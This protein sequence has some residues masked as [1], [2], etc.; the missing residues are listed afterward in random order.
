MDFY[1]KPD[2]SAHTSIVRRNPSYSG[3]TAQVPEVSSDEAPANDKSLASVKTDG[4]AGLRRVT[5]G[6]SGGTGRYLVVVFTP[7][8]GAA[9]RA[10]SD[11]KDF[12]NV[13][14]DF[15]D[16]PVAASNG[17]GNEPL[18]ISEVTAF[19][20]PS[21]S[22]TAIP[23]LPPPDRTGDFFR[24]PPADTTPVTTP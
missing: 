18:S 17:Y 10:T 14:T 6:L 20:P 2:A 23:Q 7:A 5:V 13:V 8:G 3:Q 16:S 9:P 4:G 1:L 21:T 15:K 11:G 12:K 19:G 24:P 22:I